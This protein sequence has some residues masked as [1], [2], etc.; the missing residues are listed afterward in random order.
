MNNSLLFI[1]STNI[2]VRLLTTNMKNGLT[3][4]N[5]ILCDP[6]PVT[7]LKIRPHYSH[8][9][10]QNATPPSGTSPLATYKEVTPPRI[11]SNPWQNYILD[12]MLWILDSRNWISDSWSMDLGFRFS[13]VFYSRFWKLK[14]PK[15]WFPHSGFYWQEK[16][17]CIFKGGGGR[18]P[19]K[20]FAS[21]W[22]S[23]WP[24]NKRG[25]T[26]RTP[27]LDPSLHG[28]KSCFWLR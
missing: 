23:V 17:T 5:S 9:S 21:F 16:I 10:H 22:T 26:P 14:I 6:I 20:F 19:R 13:I 15:P 24:K 8:S 18:S 7:L 3:P 2:L 25:R 27:P 1:Y 4:K 28:T 12:S 11:I